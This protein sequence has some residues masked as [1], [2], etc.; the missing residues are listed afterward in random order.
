MSANI[1]LADPSQLEYLLSTLTANDTAVIR[2]GEKTLKTYLKKT[3]CIPALLN[4]VCAFCTLE[5]Q[6]QL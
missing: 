6:L 4:Q 1:D 2:K 3:E 5:M